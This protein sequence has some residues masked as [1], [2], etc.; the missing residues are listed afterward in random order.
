MRKALLAAALLSLLGGAAVSLV[1]CGGKPSPPP[2]WV[3][4]PA[5]IIRVSGAWALY[6]MMLRWAQEYQKAHP[7]V[8]VLVWAGGTGKGVTDVFRGVVEIGMVSRGVSPEE[9]QRGGFWVP[10]AK[11]AV[12]PMANASNPVAKDLAAHGLTRDQ[13][14]ALWLEPNETTWGSLV[15]RPEAK[16]KVRAYT[17]SDVCGAAEA[18]ASYLGKRQQDLL[19]TRVAGDPGMAEAVSNDTRGLGYSNLSYAY[20]PNTERPVG[21]LLP[22]PI[23]IDGDGRIT[24]SESFYAT[25]AEVKRAIAEGVYPSPPARELSLLTKGKP[26]G[27]AREFLLW[28]LTD[29]QKYVDGAGCVEL[30]QQT[31]SAAVQKL[32]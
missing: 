25:R 18:W 4:Q 9:E 7:G 19:G 24:Q 5:S 23:D 32:R 16:D 3:K 13:C 1:S 27:P 20:D 21:G 29:G 15:S 17:R 2:S 22:V 31:L 12:L 28:V 14:A 30:S 6:P 11:D 26:Q 10:V 8:Q